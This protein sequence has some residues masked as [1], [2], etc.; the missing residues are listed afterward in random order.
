LPSGAKSASPK[1]D[2]T[3]TINL[4]GGE[5]FFN[6]KP[7]DMKSLNDRLA[8]LELGT[9]EP[10]KRVILL[11]TAA[12]TPYQNYF[13]TLATISANGGVVAIVEDDEKK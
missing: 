5:I 6:D 10:D 8:A 3:P 12:A 1:V 13:Q 4:R 9:L 2:K 11:E 7:L